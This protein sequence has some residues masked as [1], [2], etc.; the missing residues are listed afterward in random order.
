MTIGPLLHFRDRRP[1]Y[2]RPSS[3]GPVFDLLQAHQS[4][5]CVLLLFHFFDRDIQSVDG[6]CTRAHKSQAAL[7][8]N[9]SIINSL[10]APIIQMP[11]PPTSYSVAE[12]FQIPNTSP[13]TPAQTASLESSFAPPV[14]VMPS[15][16]RLPIG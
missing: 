11:N 13:T 3:C 1:T 15:R 8:A 7:S 10:Y 16:V 2:F 6:Q 5:F 14:Q 9:E 12:L 4:Y